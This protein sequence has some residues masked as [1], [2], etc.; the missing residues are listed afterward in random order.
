MTEEYLKRLK[1]AKSKIVSKYQIKQEERCENSKKLA[2]EFL[3]LIISVVESYDV[4]NEYFNTHA[5]FTEKMEMVLG[6]PRSIEIEIDEEACKGEDGILRAKYMIDSE[7]S[8]K[9]GEVIYKGLPEFLTSEDDI[10][11]FHTLKELLGKNSIDLAGCPD[12]QDNSLEIWFDAS[13]L[14]NIDIDKIDEAARKK[15]LKRVNK[16]GEEV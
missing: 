2:D 16:I 15:V 14:R 12:S 13:M 9:K 6:N 8:F 4:E 7:A 3:N 10:I 1:E 5:I 11:D